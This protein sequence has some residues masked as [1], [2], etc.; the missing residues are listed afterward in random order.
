MCVLLSHPQQRCIQDDINIPKPLRKKSAAVDTTVCS[1]TIPVAGQE[2]RG[3]ELEQVHLLNE[4]D[5]ERLQAELSG[6][7][8]E[9]EMAKDLFAEL[10]EEFSKEANLS[11]PAA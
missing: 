10:E 1:E 2:L 11:D 8:A 4:T 9:L 5:Q 3:A 7:E 6:A